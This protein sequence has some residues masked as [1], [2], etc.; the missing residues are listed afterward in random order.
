MEHVLIIYL[1][2]KRCGINEWA[3]LP[4]FLYRSGYLENDL[5]QKY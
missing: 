2:K 5:K 3:T 4:N 1:K